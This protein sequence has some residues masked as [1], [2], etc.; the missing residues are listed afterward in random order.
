VRARRN[1]R[2]D[3]DLTEAAQLVLEEYRSF[4]QGDT[5]EDAKAFGARHAAARAALAHLEHVL[6][7]ARDSGEAK[8]VEIDMAAWRER[9]PSL[10]NEETSSDDD[11]AAG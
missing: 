11:G 9:M 1:A 3:A 8:P 6:K 5:E 4:L 7:L 10:A 2:L